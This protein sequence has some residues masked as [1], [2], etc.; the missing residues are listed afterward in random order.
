[1]LPTSIHISIFH[2]HAVSQAATWNHSRNT[3]MYALADQPHILTLNRLCRT[4]QGVN[5]SYERNLSRNRPFGAIR[6]IH[7]SISSGLSPSTH[8]IYPKF[9]IST[10]EPLQAP[11]PYLTTRIFERGQCSYEDLFGAV[12]PTFE[13]N[14]AYT[15]RFMIDTKVV[16]MNWIEV[17]AGNYTLVH[18][19]RSKCQIE[20][21]TRYVGSRNPSLACIHGRAGGTNSY[22]IHPKANGPRSHPSASSVLISNARAERV[23]SRRRTKIQSSRSPTW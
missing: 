5:M 6:G 20:I 12:V 9:E 4:F 7:P 22:R 23:F 2:A 3:S 16:G 21:S 11:R 19:K 15:L 17:P 10:L 8:G 1:M 14:I 13:S 18:A